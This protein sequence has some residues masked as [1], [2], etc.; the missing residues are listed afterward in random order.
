[1]SREV[2]ADYDILID[3]IKNYSIEDIVCNDFEKSLSAFHKKYYAYLTLI[4]EIQNNILEEFLNNL[5]TEQFNYLTE[6]CSDI[7]TSFFNLFH[8]AYK[9]SKLIL[10]SSIE[11]FIKG[12]TKDEYSDVTNE[13]SL[14]EVF[15]VVKTL[16]FFQSAVPKELIENIHNIYKQLCADVHTAHE[17]HMERISALSHFPKYSK[18]EVEKI[19]QLSSKLICNYTTL[20]CIKFNLF[21]H[22]IH[23]KN[24]EIIK[25]GIE[26]KHR[27]LINNTL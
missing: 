12:F 18:D 24:L 27:P 5:I 23:Y 26:K 11:T 9:S 25:N 3:F 16:P 17:S 10:R 1:M 22:Q 14:Y 4:G 6:S 8:G 19:T 15:R 7:G 20:I 13:T 2:K 21:Y